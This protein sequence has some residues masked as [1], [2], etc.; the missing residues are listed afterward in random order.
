MAIHIKTQTKDF[1]RFILASGLLLIIYMAALAAMMGSS[2]LAD[3]KFHYLQI[4]I[5]RDKNLYILENLTTIPGYHW[6][7][8]MISLATGQD[9]IVFFRAINGLFGIASSILFLGLLKKINHHISIEKFI[10]YSLLPISFP[11]HFLVYTDTLSLFLVISGIYLALEKRFNLSGFVLFLGLL[12][13]QNNIIWLCLGFI[14]YCLDFYANKSQL[15]S[16][17]TFLRGG[18]AFISGIV[19]FGLFVY[20]NR[21]VALGD[22]SMHPGSELSLGNI[23]FFLFLYFFLFLPSITKMM[24]DL[25]NKRKTNNVKYLYLLGVFFSLYL[26]YIFK[27]DVIHPYNVQWQDYFL[28]NKPLSFMVS[29]P[30]SKTLYFIPIGLSAIHVY[31]RSISSPKLLLL[32]FLIAIFLMPSSLIEQRYFI[33]PFSLLIATFPAENRSIEIIT[34]ILYLILSFIFISLISSGQFFL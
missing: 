21:G 13:R 27:F 10:Q 2:L 4:M 6:I 15:L 17:P 14:I 9:S 22:K 24:F 26:I 19:F 25:S 29:S 31:Q 11:Y 12:I 33:I 8:A 23:F 30:L 28:R 20:I 34:C 3:E 5:F 32:F 7:I 16:R 1:R 18:M